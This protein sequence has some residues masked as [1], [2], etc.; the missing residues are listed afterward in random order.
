M[1][2]ETK[3][4]TVE[5]LGMSFVDATGKAVPPD[6]VA[7]LVE[8]MVEQGL[9]IVVDGKLVPNP[10]VQ[11]DKMLGID[12]I[13][14]DSGALVDSDVLTDDEVAAELGKGQ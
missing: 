11:K 5:V 1:T 9:L 7:A 8:G 4:P 2:G 13:L 6:I 3:P 10:D 12:L 14:D